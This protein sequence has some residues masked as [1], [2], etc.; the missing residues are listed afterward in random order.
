MTTIER[1]AHLSY[2]GRHRFKLGRWWDDGLPCMVF[3]MVNPSTADHREDD[4]TIRRCMAFAQREGCGGIEV[5]NLYTLRTPYPR[6]LKCSDDI[7]RP[8][9]IAAWDS[10]LSSEEES[11][12]VAAWGSVADTLH[13]PPSRALTTYGPLVEWH[14]LGLS[15]RGFPRHPL[16]LSALTPLEPYCINQQK[17]ET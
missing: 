10:V 14:S 5:L 2:D 11:T 16:Y 1:W 4:R 13:L 6:E 17:E 3:V 8:D 9:N 7:E 12:I 15:K